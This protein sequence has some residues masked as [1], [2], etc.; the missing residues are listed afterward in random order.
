MEVP[1]STTVLADK[2]QLLPGLGNLLNKYVAALLRSILLLS[3]FK[4]SVRAW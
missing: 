4:E 1:L 2:D 3:K